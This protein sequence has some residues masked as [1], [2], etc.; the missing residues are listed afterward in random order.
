MKINKKV[1]F[2][3][4]I[5]IITLIVGYFARNSNEVLHAYVEKKSTS[6]YTWIQLYNDILVKI[7]KD[8]VVDIPTEE[9]IKASLLGMEKTLDA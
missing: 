7:K 1:L 6:P 3:V 4:N 2:T 9:L 8:Y 5:L